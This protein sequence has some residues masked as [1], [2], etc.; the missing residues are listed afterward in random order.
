[1][2]K[3]ELKNKAFKVAIAVLT[4]STLS[5][6]A[7]RRP[8]TN[9]AAPQAITPLPEGIQAVIAV[10]LAE[11]LDYTNQIYARTDL[12][13]SGSTSYEQ[14]LSDFQILTQKIETIKNSISP[15][16]HPILGSLH[17]LTQKL[18][19]TQKKWSEAIK[20][21]KLSQMK[22]KAEEISRK[23][24]LMLDNIF[25]P[26]INKKRTNGIKQRLQASGATAELELLKKIVQNIDQIFNYDGTHHGLKT[27]FDKGMFLMRK[28]G[29][30]FNYQ[31]PS[32]YPIKLM[33]YWNRYN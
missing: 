30:T 19:E 24:K 28:K 29:F 33:D 27:P 16:A 3:F 25:G 1:M 20:L 22:E 18:Y 8:A 2:K 11:L 32:E 6:E 15:Q 5:V 31:S 14:D 4:L 9:V 12:F 23:N 21:R 10:K 26:E 7:V 17:G 13:F